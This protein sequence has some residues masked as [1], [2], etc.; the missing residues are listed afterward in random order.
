[1]LHAAAC[2][3]LCEVVRARQKTPVSSHVLAACLSSSGVRKTSLGSL[4]PLQGL[5]LG[6]LGGKTSKNALAASPA[7]KEEDSI[8]LPTS[9]VIAFA[10]QAIKR[11]KV[12]MKNFR[13]SNRVQDLTAQD[14]QRALDS[15]VA[16]RV[17]AAS[18]ELE[19][20]QQEARASKGW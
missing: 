17:Q 8:C 16:R 1:M 5:C 2:C 9:K 4:A 15:L 7:L 12:I 20:S 13:Q 19:A 18:R 11:S 14:V 10:R 6:K 3:L